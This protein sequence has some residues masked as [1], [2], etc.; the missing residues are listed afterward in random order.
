MK[1]F[2]WLT[3]VGRVVAKPVTAPVAAVKR[4]AQ[5]TMQAAIAGIIRH[6]LTAL[7]GG[8]VASGTLSGDD[9][10]AAIGAITT[11]VGIAWSVFAKRK[12][13]TA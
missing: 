10:N 5:K 11:L 3:T 8:L 12:A 4:G 9:L 2:G 7:G 6:I 1:G 13:A